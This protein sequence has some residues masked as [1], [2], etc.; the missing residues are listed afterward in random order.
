MEGYFIHSC[1]YRR[2]NTLSLFA[3]FILSASYSLCHGL[4]QGITKLPIIVKGVQSLEDVE[5]CVKN[6]VEGVVIVS[7]ILPFFSM[8]HISILS[9]IP[10]TVN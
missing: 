3:F 6:G 9:D 5:L 8:N 2:V 1:E 4:L 10:S 7:G